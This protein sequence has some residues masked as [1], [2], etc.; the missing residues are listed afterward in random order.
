MNDDPNR[1]QQLDLF[2]APVLAVPVNPDGSVKGSKVIYAPQGPAGEYAPLATNP[3]RGCGHSCTYCSVPITQHMDRVEF[4]A[5]AV[6]KPDYIANLREDAAK[7]QAAG[8]TEQVLLCF[9]TDPYHPGDTKPT[10]TTLEILIEHGLAVS[11]LSKGGTRMLR[12]LDLLRPSRDAYA[13][14]L[15]SLDDNFSRKWERKARLP[16]DRIAALRAAHDRGI[17]TWVSIEPVI[18]VEHSLAA[19]A[20]THEFVD[21]YKVGMMNYLT[22]PIDWPDFTLRMIEMLNRVGAKH[23]VKRDLQC[24][25]P[26][27]YPNPMRVPQHHGDARAS[28][29]GS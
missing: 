13:A 22:L 10:R 16:G 6:L 17:F 4:N 20:A 27:G 26:P 11:I 23:Y 29:A 21:L 3:Y 24:F 2:G 14:T 1:K 9:G 25:L 7:Y 19:V 15:T 8:I 5:G 12:D 18:D 28:G